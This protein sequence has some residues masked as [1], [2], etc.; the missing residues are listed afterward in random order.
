MFDILGRRVAVLVNE[1][2]KVGQY[3][4]D[5]DASRLSS[6]VY[7]YRL[8]SEGFVFSKKMMLMK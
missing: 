4:V 1:T 8:S 2:Q 7:V 3:K 5:F 6:G